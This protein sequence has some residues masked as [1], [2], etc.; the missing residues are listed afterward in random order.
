MH[1]IKILHPKEGVT[2]AAVKVPDGAHNFD[3]VGSLLW[4]RHQEKGQLRKFS[5]LNIPEGNWQIL[6]FSDQLRE[7]QCAELFP[8]SV[9]T[10]MH[11]LYRTVLDKF[12][13]A[14]GVY[15]KNPY[16]EKPVNKDFYWGYLSDLEQWQEAE[17][18]TGSWIILKKMD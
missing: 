8:H 10:K 3:I 2:I 15:S 11:D 12:L 1:N 9:L 17:A 4:F 14:N 6:G 7:E 16:G 18:N 5:N 13:E